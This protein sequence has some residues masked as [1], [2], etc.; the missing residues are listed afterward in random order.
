MRNFRERLALDVGHLRDTEPRRVPCVDLDAAIA[1]YTGTLGYRLDMIMPADA[2]RVAVL[3]GPDGS[4]RLEIERAAPEE[5]PSEAAQ[6]VLTRAG[7]ANAWSVGRAGM[8]YRDLIPGRLG[9]RYIGSHIRIADGGPVAD[10][11]HYHQVRFQMIY[12]MQGWVRVVYEDQGEP[13]VLHAGDCVLQPPTI[14]HRVLESSPRLEV[15]EIG[16]PAEHETFREHSITLPTASIQPER[17]FGGQR[18]VRHIAA[19]AGWQPARETGFEFRDTGIAAATDGLASVRVLR[20]TAGRATAPHAAHSRRQIHRGDFLFLQVLDG[21]LDLSSESLGE[22]TLDAGD[23][24]VIPS[25]A[26]YSLAASQPCELL[27]VAVS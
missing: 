26:D 3:S 6:F 20:V 2:P 27:E 16:G 11:V 8:H 15:I 19:Q 21:R 23:A 18:F 24:C 17:R 25:G 9:G 5:S 7:A 10:Y 4:V 14:R 22:H 13:F 12:C 1:L